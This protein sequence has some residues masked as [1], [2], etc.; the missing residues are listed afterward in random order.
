ML[1]SQ[2]IR[3]LHLLEPEELEMLHLFV[4]SPIFHDRHHHEDTRRLFEYVKLRYPDFTDPALEKKQVG[5][6]L[7]AGRKDPE[8]DVTRAMAHLMHVVRQFINFRYSAVRGGHIA[9]RG[10]RE[11]LAQNPMMLLNFARQQ[12]AMMRFYSERLRQKTPP[13][14]TANPVAAPSGKKRRKPENFFQNL[15]AELRDVMAQPYDFSRFEDYEFSDFHFYRFLLEQEKAIFDGAEENFEGDDNLLAASESL[16]RFY[17]LSKLDLTSRLVHRHHIGRPFEQGTVEAKHYQENLDVV[18]GIVQII[19]ER[20]YTLTP[21][22]QLYCSLIVF[23]TQS[24]PQSADNEALR[25]NQMLDELAHEVPENRRE[26]FKTLLRSHWTRRYAQSKKRA[27]LERLH[28]LHL[29]QV[30]RLRRLG[31]GMPNSYFRN[32]IQVAVKLGHATWADQFIDEFEGKLTRTAYPELTVDIYRAVLRFTEGRLK[33]ARKYMPHYFAYGELDDIYLY[34]IAATTDVKLH[35]EL[36]TLED[37]A[38]FNMFRATQTRIERAKTLPDSRREERLNF[39]RILRKFISIKKKL[40]TNPKAN[41]APA[42]AEIRGL[43]DTWPVV[44]QE[45]LV[46]KWRALTVDR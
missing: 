14:P 11:E 13:T 28:Q 20:G 3:T 5:A 19:R 38:G 22:I 40:A 2:L 4:A 39:Y 30:E 36:D 42:L 44:E 12:L 17:L 45:W 31:Q 7:F 1:D 29:D 15:Y 23:Q 8:F 27:L 32:I 41:I 6:A 46:E 24:D 35:Y 21:G 26:D 34:S 9:R 25:F 10:A 43:L 16:D 37:E 33:D 18:L